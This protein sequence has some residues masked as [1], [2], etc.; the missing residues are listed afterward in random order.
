MPSSAIT[1]RAIGEEAGIQ[2]SLVNRH[3]GSK[4]VLV[5]IAIEQLTSSWIAAMLDGPPDGLIDRA[6]DYL[7][8]HPFD[9]AGIRHL[10][11][12]ESTFVD[13]RSPVVGAIV[14]HFASVGRRVEAVD[15]SAALSLMLGWMAAEDH[16]VLSSEVPLRRAREVV[17]AHARHCL[18]PSAR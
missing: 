12:D 3:F 14:S 8:E 2:F 1:I 13:G 7:A 16:W 15:V 11:V 18:E 9:V 6:V 4:D 10:T 5:R 17:K